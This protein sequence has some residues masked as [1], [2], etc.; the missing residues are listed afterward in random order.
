MWL[1]ALGGGVLSVLC[2]GQLA[3]SDDQGAGGGFDD[4]VGDGVELVDLQ[5]AVDLGE[6]AF[7]EPEVPASDAGDGGDGL[8]VC[9]VRWVECL[10]EGGP[11]PLQDEE[12]FVIAQRSVL[13]GEAD[14][15]VE[16]WVE[17]P[18]VS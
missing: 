3:D 9:E 17:S 8:G 12:Q 15:A 13:V 10:A 11:V 16:L 7:Q 6:E 2:G 5:D 1:T 4:V 18:R 14:A